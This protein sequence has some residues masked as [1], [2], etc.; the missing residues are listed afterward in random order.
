MVLEDAMCKTLISFG[1]AKI[2]AMKKSAKVLDWLHS[3][4]SE[5]PSADL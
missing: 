1:R 5:D 2:N 4:Y 3:Q